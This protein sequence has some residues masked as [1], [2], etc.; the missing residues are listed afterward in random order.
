MS[1]RSGVQ[2]P[3]SRARA[4]ASVRLCASNLSGMWL[5]CPLTVPTVTTHR[6]DQ[7]GA[8]QSRGGGQRLGVRLKP[9]RFRDILY[10]AVVVW[11][12]F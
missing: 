5:T 2:N 6:P 8:V 3:G 11:S 7:E 12:L 9:G 1:L 10:V 4:T